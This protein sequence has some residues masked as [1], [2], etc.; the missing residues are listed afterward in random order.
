MQALDLYNKLLADNNLQVQLGPYSPRLLQ[1][2]AILLEKP[3]IVVS[4]K[5]EPQLALPE[6]TGDSNNG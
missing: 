5:P 2:G 3:S 6:H 4:Y 1:D